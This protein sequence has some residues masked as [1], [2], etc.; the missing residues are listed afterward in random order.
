MYVQKKVDKTVRLL[1][2]D[3]TLS[4]EMV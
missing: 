1:A 4:A 3:A 2:Q